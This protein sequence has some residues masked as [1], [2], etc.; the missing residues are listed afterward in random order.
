MSKKVRYNVDVDGDLDGRIKGMMDLT[1]ART[2]AEIFNYAFSF[3]DWALREIAEGRRIASV[4]P[5]GEMTRVEMPP[6]GN[7]RSKKSREK[8]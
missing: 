7:V 6:F 8:E 3:Y 1:D 2:K 5:K 4:G